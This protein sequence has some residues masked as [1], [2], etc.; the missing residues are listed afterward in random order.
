MSE[1]RATPKG[2][3]T[4]RLGDVGP[5]YGGGT[6]SKFEPRFWTNG[7]IPWVSPKDMKALRITDSQDHLSA[8]AIQETNIREF[9]SGTVLFVIRSGILAR[10]FPVGV[11]EVSGTMNQDLKGVRPIDGVEPLFLAYQLI[12]R[13]RE[14]LNGCS[15]HGTTVASIDTERLHDFEVRMAPPAEQIRIV[16]KIEELFSDLDAGVAALERVRVSLKRYRASVLKAAVEGRLTE[17]W[18]KRN[19]VQESGEQLLERILADRRAK[20]EQEQLRKFKEAGKTPPKGWREKWIDP[21]TAQP[22]VAPLL[23][24]DWC[25]T[26]IGGVLTVRGGYAFKSDDYCEEGVP[27]IRQADLQH[28]KVVVDTAKRLPSRLLDECPGWTLQKGDL[29]VGMSGSIGKVAVYEADTP[30]LQNQRTGLLIPHPPIASTYLTLMMEYIVPQLLKKGKG[31]AVQNV[32]ATD[33][34]ECDVPLPPLAEQSA[35]FAE[36]DRRL[37]V[38]DAAEQQ[39]EHTLQRAARLRQAILKRAFEGSLVEQNPNDEPISALSDRLPGNKQTV[40]NPTFAGKRSK[41]SAQR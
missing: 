17:E 27:L 24:G 19:P 6:P 36:V 26:K 25:W 13:E 8:A 15:K 21:A 37:S 31:I 33:I 16:A 18:R 35:I 9:P 23:P 12:G 10:T 2:W 14:V 34:E 30:A 22:S 28:G 3:T 7:T 40:G 1:A 39:I 38:A 5:W 4:A 20:W 29:L 32:S 11:A 41:V